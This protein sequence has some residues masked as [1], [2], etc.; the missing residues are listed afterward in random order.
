MKNDNSQIIKWIL[1]R[2]VNNFEIHNC[3]LNHTLQ[4][5]LCRRG[6]NIEEE[7]SDFLSPKDLPNPEDHFNELSKATDRIIVACQNNEKIAICGDYDADGIT[8]TV[9]LVELLS[10]IGGK[11]I[12]FIPSRQ[13]DGYGLNTKM[14]N[15]I[16]SKDIKLII[17]VDNGISA[18]DAI[19]RCNELDIELIITDHH[20]ITKSAINVYALIHPELSPIDS[21]YKYLAGVGIAF[22]LASN[23][24][25]KLK[26]NIDQT[27]A[28]VLFCIGTVADMAPLI[29]ANRK[30]LKDFLP[31]MTST[32]NIGIKTI[33]KKLD[34]HDKYISSDDI[35]FKIAPLINAVGR[36]AD[37]Q[38]IIDL[39]TNSSETTIKK[40]T[41]QCFSINQQRKKITALVEQDA[42]K[43]ALNE[44]FNNR[45][46]FVLSN[47]E[48]H[49]G[50]IGIVAARIVDKYNVPTAIISLGN[51]GLYRGSIRSIKELKVNRA[52]EECS[53]LLI[54][55]G[56]HSA[57]AGFTIR[58]E[59]ID[60]LREKLNN[61]AIREFSKCNLNKTINPDA[62]IKLSDIN[63]ELYGQL[64]LIGPFGIMNKAPLFWTRK[65]KICDLCRLRGNHIKMS[66]D[67]GTATIDAIK[68]NFPYQ[69]KLND[70]IDIA[71]Y[72]EMN[73]WKNINKLQL[74]IIDIKK[75]KEVIDLQIHNNN[76][77]CQLTKNMN[78]M[79]TNNKG[80]FLR[81]DSP[82]IF[83]NDKK[84]MNLFAK[85]ILSFA[86]IA[87]A[88]TS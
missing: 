84:H 47:S 51:D 50:I 72:V 41:K 11:P 26:F 59:N 54:A 17:T 8:S 20:K 1:P 48:W 85:K 38:L 56:G 21:P 53:E 58:K 34:I 29:G 39:L 73:K 82:F 12:P 57:A 67:D 45:K 15:N 55:H 5:V 46:F 80:K 88:K 13:D 77:K 35:G 32:Y 86:E 43:V 23:I 79:V 16:N 76:Y 7:L 81:S 25:T 63:M 62:H 68:W 66:L 40:L 6:I 52:L 3:K 19:N 65:C 42:M 74:N 18:F 49:P 10:K 4:K 9:L 24:C 28:N 14:I 2:P 22:M 36:I 30:W 69:L 33:F 27:S 31:K 78:I 83:N 75:H 70:Y 87:L 60:M 64:N 37:P 71:F 61:I 44:Y